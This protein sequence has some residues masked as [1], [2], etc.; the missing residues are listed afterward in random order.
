MEQ[1]NVRRVCVAMLR[2]GRSEASILH[3]SVGVANVPMHPPE[4]VTRKEGNATQ[5]CI[6]YK[7]SY[8]PALQ[9]LHASHDM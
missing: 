5:C 8:R 7:I 3:A 2:L 1:R 6:F 9:V 4:S